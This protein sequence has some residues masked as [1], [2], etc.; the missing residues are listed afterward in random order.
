MESRSKD[1]IL[2]IG[3]LSYNHFNFIPECLDSILNQKTTYN[4]RIF[5]IDDHSYDNTYNILLEEYKKRFPELIFIH[6][7]ESNLGPI[8]SA[9]YLATKLK[10]KYITFLDGDDYWCYNNKLQEQID[11]LEN[12]PDYA[13]CFHDA[14]IKQENSGDDEYLKKTQ[15]QWKTYSQFNKYSSDFMPWALIQRNIIPTASLVFRNI[16]LTT[17]LDSYRAKEFSLSWALHLEIIKNSK[18]K[19]F[20]QTWSVY[21]DHPEGYSKKHRLTDFKFNNISILETLLKDPAWNY[22]KAD[23]YRSICNEYRMILKSTC[24]TIDSFKEYKKLL[25][26]YS[27]YLKLAQKEDLKQLKNDYYYVRHNRMVE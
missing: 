26:Q 12:N 13:G 21:R 10:S 3:I 7:N 20:N 22:Y 8:K 18:F 25:K 11:F 15:N 6:R 4:F 16:N 1:F 14:L 2:D 24:K 27:K 17:F 9:K 5:I 19:Y 23:I